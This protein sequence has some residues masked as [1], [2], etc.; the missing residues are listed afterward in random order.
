MDTRQKAQEP[1]ESILERIDAIS[2]EA[3]QAG[4]T[5][6]LAHTEHAFTAGIGEGIA[7]FGRQYVAILFAAKRKALTAISR[8][9]LR[10]FP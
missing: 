1:S 9:P 3:G 5:V 7:E 6:M 4:P 10:H 2:A 8:S